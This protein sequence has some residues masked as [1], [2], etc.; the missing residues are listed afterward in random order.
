MT[1]AFNNDT[2]EVSISKVLQSTEE[3]EHEDDK[4]HDSFYVIPETLCYP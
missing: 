3:H 1:V 2:L 4:L